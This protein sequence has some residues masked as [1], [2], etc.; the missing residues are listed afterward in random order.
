MKNYQDSIK[1]YDQGLKLDPSNKSCL[2]GKN[3]VVNRKVWGVDQLKTYDEYLKVI[4]T[5]GKLVIIDYFA[6]WC[7]PCKMI[8]PVFVKI[9]E[10]LGDKVLMAKVDVDENKHAAGA[11][12]IQ[13]MPTFKFFRDGREIHTMSG[14]NEA[15]LR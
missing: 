14:A 1:A 4:G 15:G 11:A 2:D 5:Q 10:E 6:T 7:P 13:S 3:A 8:G 12:G 9:A